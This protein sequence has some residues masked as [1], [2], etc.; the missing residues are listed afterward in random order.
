[1]KPEIAALRDQISDADPAALLQALHEFLQRE[2]MS[3][4][5]LRAILQLQ[6]A[7]NDHKRGKPNPLLAVEKASG[8]K[9]LGIDLMFK[10]SIAAT[11]T[12]LQGLGH[13]KS[14]ARNIIAKR[15]R[16]SGRNVTATLVET[17]H[18]ETTASRASPDVRDEYNKLVASLRARLSPDPHADEEA[19]LYVLAQLPGHK[20]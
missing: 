14:D 17:W 15:L 12:V 7:L 16:D 13:R 20:L 5:D 19:L 4:R 10:T 18:R 3:H 8:G 6:F 11:M 9:S 1:M 2:G